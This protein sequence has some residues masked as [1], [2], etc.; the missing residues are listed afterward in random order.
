MKQFIFSAALLSLFFVSCKKISGNGPVVSQNRST[1]TFTAIEASVGGE[2]V[3]TP[4]PVTQVTIQAQQNILDIIDTRVVNGELRIEFE[5]G[6]I[7]GRHDDIRVTVSG[8]DVTGLTVT[9]SGNLLV[10]QP[11]QPQQAALSVNG[12]GAITVASL[13]TGS[14]NSKISGS[15]RITV[16]GGTAATAFADISGSGDID[17]LNLS[18]RT[19]GVRISGSGTA[20]LDVSEALDATISGSGNVYYKGNPRITTHVSGSGKVVA[21]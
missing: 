14:L 11:W 7:V 21:W 16:G 13:Q 9:G 10:A 2:V 1:G 12:S 20:K 5:S 15:G 4:G 3:Y 6:K 17:H 8:P 18:A 19:A